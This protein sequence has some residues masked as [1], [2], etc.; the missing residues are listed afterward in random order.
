MKDNKF[1]PAGTV[2]NEDK[3]KNVE[4]YVDPA[5]SDEK[6]SLYEYS[7]WGALIEAV[8]VIGNH[9]DSNSPS[10]RRDPNWVKPIAIQKYIDERTPSML[11]EN[12]VERK[13]HQVFEPCTT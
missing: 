4:V 7:R 5:R 3:C 12:A 6:M 13:I 9:I 1:P 2:V 10:G 8:G 11:H